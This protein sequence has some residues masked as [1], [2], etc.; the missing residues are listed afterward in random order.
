MNGSTLPLLI[1]VVFFVHDVE[2]LTFSPELLRDVRAPYVF[3]ITVK[4]IIGST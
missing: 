3:F 4:K 2:P 1:F